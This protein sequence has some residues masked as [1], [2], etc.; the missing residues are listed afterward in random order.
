MRWQIEQFIFCEREQTLTHQEQVSQLEP[1]A[2]ELL[3]YFCRHQ[4]QIISREALIEQVW[5]GR[6]ITDNAVSKVITKLRK[7]L[8][9]DAKKPKFI[10]TFPKKGYKFIAN[11][12][13]VSETPEQVQV[14]SN[15]VNQTADTTVKTTTNKLPNLYYLIVAALALF[16]LMKYW[17][18]TPVQQPITQV[19][20]L[21]RDSGRESR[22]QISPDN[23]YLAYVEVHDKKMR[24]WIKSLAD[25]TR[26]EISHGKESTVWVDS[27]SW[28]SDGSKFVYLVTTPDS[29]RYFI[30]SF[31]KM[32]LGEAQLIH[33][34]PAGSYG[35]IAYTHDDNRL[36]YSEN[37]GRNTPFTLFEMN[38]STQ[39]KRKVNQPEIFLGGN[40]QFD[41]HPLENK[42][43][44]SSP[45]KQQWEGFYS[46]DL[47]TDELTLL[48][49]QDAYIC[50]GRWSHDGKRIVLMGEHPATELVSFDLNGENRQVVYSGSEQVSVPERHNN[51]KDYLF[52]L[53]KLNQN[54]SYYSFANTSKNE[55]AYSSVDDSLA[56]FA[57]HGEQIAYVSVSSG[58][59]ELWLTEP[60]GKLNKKLTHFNDNRHY[61]DLVW[62]LSGDHLLA[63]TL[64]ELHL[65]DLNSGVSTV[66]KIPQVEIR[67]VSWKNNNTIAYSTRT[68]NDWRVNYYDITTEQ[69]T[70]EKENWRYIRHSKNP[71]DILW[72]DQNGG[73]FVGQKQLKVLDKEL[74]NT[75]FIHGRQFNLK[76][77]GTNWA[78]QQRIKGKYQLNLKQQ[79]DLPAKILLT[80]DSYHFD[81][82]AFG[83]LYHTLESLNADIYQ[84]VSD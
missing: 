81:L 39:E 10:A 15:P 68:D 58:S 25:E 66:L 26:I 38:L 36:I 41:L 61:V 80:T 22:P 13:E 45:D 34:C 16:G 33:N 24:Q 62:S 9:D 48:F 27:L 59:E 71:D 31:E 5:L 4:D 57:H 43:L 72:L 12:S 79:L 49:K 21:T 7:T 51:G 50:C 56:V 32:V 70:P 74:L 28:N 19:K 78:W 35:K 67:A 3:A 60:S 42:I 29:C 83:V 63:L 52:P 6:V 55:I 20:A 1:I 46:L 69:V 76:K 8:N 18:T 73:L 14:E 84:T 2:V 64:N 65:I 23:Q 40:S 75:D 11:A 77:S 17:L 47:A 53:V 54:A 30:R 37:S 44:I 82:S